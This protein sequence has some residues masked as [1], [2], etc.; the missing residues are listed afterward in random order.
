[1]SS[2]S[3][4]PLDVL[5][6]GGGVAA[7][8]GALA[9][10]ALA[11]ESVKLRLLAPAKQF[12][13]RPHTVQEPF[14]FARAQRYPLDEIARD[15]DIE[16]I[17][18]ALVSV[19]P[20][21][22]TVT[23]DAGETL[24]YGALLLGLGARIRPRYEH[25]V[26]ID[27]AQLD[28]LLHGL[29]QD[30]EAGL[31]KRLAFVAP[32]RMAWPLP[33]Y[34]LAMMTAARAYEMGTAVAITIITP[35]DSPLAVFGERASRTVQQRLTA[36]GIEVVAS[37]YAEIPGGGE[38]I[39]SPGD[40]RMQFDRVVALP[41]LGG[42]AVPGLPADDHG[43]IPVDDHCQVRGLEH[44][45][46]AG[47]ASDFPIKHGGIAAQQADAA[48]EAI[49]ASAGTDVHPEP[50]RPVILG[51]LFTGERPIYMSAHLT[52]G[53]GITSEASETPAWEPRAKIAAKYLAPYLER[54]DAAR[55]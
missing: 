28:E 54:R 48:A 36:A 5:I 34:E 35:E 51:V 37:A 52:G 13:Y 3:A 4:Q 30:V 49:A 14:A 17:E 44:V 25:A 7:L 10:K 26:T 15:L 9:L 40:R 20:S 19:D 42:P 47:D 43:F 39:V 6:A 31:A 41:E 55:R 50:L 16:L 8:E 38:V 27:D 2:N 53:Q 33:I 11:G 23:T 45:Y 46:A 21:A 18:D 24:G 12:V 29:V 32:A 22:R 1:M